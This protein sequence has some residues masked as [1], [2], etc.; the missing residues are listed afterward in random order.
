MPYKKPSAIKLDF[1]DING[2]EAKTVETLNRIQK[3]LMSTL[4]EGDVFEASRHAID[5]TKGQVSKTYLV[6]KEAEAK[7]LE[8]INA[9]SMNFAQ[10]PSISTS[11]A[12][13]R[14]Y[15]TNLQGEKAIAY[16]RE[17]A[18]RQGGTFKAYEGGKQELILPLGEG[19]HKAVMGK[20][21]EYSSSYEE[22]EAHLKEKETASNAKEAQRADEA[23][24]KKAKKEELQKSKDEEKARKEADKEEAKEALDKKKGALAMFAKV[25]LAVL[26]LKKIIGIIGDILAKASERGKQVYSD[27]LQGSKLN[28]SS[29]Q[30]LRLRTAGAYRG[31]GEAPLTSTAQMQ[32][33]FGTVLSLNA[34]KETLGDLAILLGD[35]VAG[36]IEN[37]SASGGTDPTKMVG[38]IT[39]NIIPKII[40][41]K[42]IIDNDTDSKSALASWTTE[43]SRILGDDFGDLISAMYHTSQN[44][45]LSPEA[46]AEGLSFRGFTSIPAV[47]MPTERDSRNLEQSYKDFTKAVE[48]FKASVDTFTLRLSPTVLGAVTPIVAHATQKL[49]RAQGNW[50]LADLMAQGAHAQNLHSST[51]IDTLSGI[52]QERF[53]R[54]NNE[55]LIKNRNGRRS[56]YTVKEI[57][58]FNNKGKLPSNLTDAQKTQFKQIAYDWTALQLLKF[59]KE[60]VDVQLDNKAHGRTVAPVAFSME[61]IY[62]D[63]DRFT[64]QAYSREVG[65]LTEVVT[66]IKG[67]LNKREVQ[68]V[69]PLSGK[70][71][72]DARISADVE[73]QAFAKRNAIEV[74]SRV[75]LE[76]YYAR[77][78]SER[79]KGHTAQVGEAA[80]GTANIHI[81]LNGE[82]VADEQVILGMPTGGASDTSITTMLQGV[83]SE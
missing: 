11:T 70:S 68:K 37:F 77:N 35:K 69:R 14:T 74:A 34:N 1:S 62:T 28:L 51:T 44:R 71:L 83:N 63:V 50:A 55:G 65:Y 24:A 40:A 4:K 22:K 79:G 19:R 60:E 72:T 67:W 80:N 41:G 81:Y 52:H 58:E 18:I 2:A 73:A 20:A 29:T 3:I 53:Y 16:A 78:P 38:I 42:D 82:Q 15:N 12:K 75:A 25:S 33:L 54:L 17:N 26:L 9:Q 27:A 7:A 56:G 59:K 43:I 57:N 76:Q 10:E 46:R 32:Q 6:A 39:D 8:L 47:S 13:T 48:S 23:E 66:V 45:N 36:L 61:E 31:I 5:Y 30:V 49:E 21:G 64:K